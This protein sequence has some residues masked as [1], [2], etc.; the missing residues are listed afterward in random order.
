MNIS[1]GGSSPGGAGDFGS[2]TARRLAK[3]GAN[4]V[5]ADVADDRGK[6]LASELGGGAINVRT[7]IIDEASIVSA[8]DTAVNSPLAAGEGTGALLAEQVT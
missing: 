2:S 1:N 7:D 6:T 3:L 8:V 5:I 4:V